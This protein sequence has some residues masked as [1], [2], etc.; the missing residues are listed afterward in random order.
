MMMSHDVIQ[1]MIN[2]I[3]L[4]LILTNTLVR[5]YDVIIIIVMG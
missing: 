5:M 3:R 2:I 4:Y 1:C